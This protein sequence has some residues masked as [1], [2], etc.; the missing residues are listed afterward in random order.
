MAVSYNDIFEDVCQRIDNDLEPKG[1]S[2]VGDG[3]TRVVRLSNRGICAGAAQL[4]LL[5]T[6]T[7]GVDTELIEDIDYTLDHQS[8]TVT[9]AAVVPEGTTL[10]AEYYVRYWSE[11][12][13]WRL[14]NQS[15]QSLYPSFY[16]ITTLEPTLDDTTGLY[17]LTDDDSRELTRVLYAEDVGGGSDYRLRPHGQYRV[18]RGEANALSL[19]LFETLSGTL[20]VTCACRPGAFVSATTTLDDLELP[21]SMRESIVLWT[22]WQALTQ[23]LPRRVRNDTTT[24]IAQEG[25]TTFFDQVRQTTVFKALLDAELQANHM[26]PLTARGSL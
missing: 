22:C 24:T 20:T 25:R 4:P 9:L 26:P 12:L 8:G 11:Q 7:G 15:L 14:V 10:Y 23:K 18:L 5:Y 17:P 21:D 19:R 16:A 6:T 2:F 3:T 13:L 1:D